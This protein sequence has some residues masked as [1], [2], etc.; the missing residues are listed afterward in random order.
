MLQFSNS[1]THT[2]TLTLGSAADA[3]VAHRLL[4]RPKFRLQGSRAPADL[5][6]PLSN[7][8]QVHLTVASPSPLFPRLGWA[9]P[10]SGNLIVGRS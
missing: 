4:M 10:A 8:L 1:P 3:S 9:E 6:G 5:C 7:Q 2:P